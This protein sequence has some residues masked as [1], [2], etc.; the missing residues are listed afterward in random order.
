MRRR[1]FIMGGT[2]AVSCGAWPL[3]ARAQQPAMPVIGFL[4]TATAQSYAG[5]VSYFLQGLK[6]TGFVDGQNVAIDY[7][8]A[9]DEYDRLPELAADLVRRRVSLIVTS[10][11]ILAPRAAKAASATTPIVFSIGS[12]PVAAG[13]VASLN[14]PGGNITGATILNDDAIQKRA[15]LLHDLLPNTRVFGLLVNPDN[16]APNSSTGRT[17][18]DMIGDALRV[19]GGTVHV[20]NTRRIDEFD[21][22]FASLIEKGAGAMFTSADAIFASGRER[23]VALAA[24][25]AIPMVYATREAAAAGGLMVYTASINDSYLQ[26]GR[27]AGRV[28][29]GEKPADLPVLL[30][31]RFEFIIN[32]KTAKTLGLTVPPGLLA[33]VDEAIE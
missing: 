32:L 8:W 20:A 9:N 31:T 21:A 6:E 28:L 5:R 15:Q 18:T 30:P 16:N 17:S 7:R 10:G 33:I 27:Y 24:R 4:G 19:W 11:N 13:L 25:H 1:E 26:N 22:A 2:A 23:L 14:K 12:D 3:V 29:K